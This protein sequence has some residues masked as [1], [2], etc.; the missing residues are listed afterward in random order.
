[1]NIEDDPKLTAYIIDEL[2]R[3]EQ[4]Q[5]VLVGG[6]SGQELAGAGVLRVVS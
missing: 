6:D 4:V 2:D 5:G 1:M 3:D